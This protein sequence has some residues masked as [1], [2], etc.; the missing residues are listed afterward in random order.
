MI[1]LILLKLVWIG[2]RV[3]GDLYLLIVSWS[4]FRNRLEKDEMMTYDIELLSELKLK[5]GGLYISYIP[6]T[7]TTTGVDKAVSLS[8]HPDSGMGIKTHH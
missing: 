8:Y 6:T 2:L 7:I 5:L 4:Y 1:D 3:L